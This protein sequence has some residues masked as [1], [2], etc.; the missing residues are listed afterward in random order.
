MVGIIVQNDI[1]RIPEPVIAVT[2]V[3]R[4]DGEVEAAE[5]EPARS[6]ASQS[7]HVPRPEA[8]GEMPV[9]PWVI[10]MI[11]RVAGTSIMAHP[12]FTVVH[13]RSVRMPR[14]VVEV[15]IFLGRMRSGYL[16]GPVFG[17]VL[18]ASA[19][20]WPGAVLRYC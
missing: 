15:S 14:L 5:P 17:N 2:D 11:V 13:M 18:T 16:R 1:I 19:N 10:E 7:P 3:V 9:L 6:T 12:F 4:S 20:L 8:A